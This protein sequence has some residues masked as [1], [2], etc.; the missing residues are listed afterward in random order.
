MDLTDQDKQ[1]IVNLLEQVSVPVKDAP[2]I[3]SIIVKLQTQLKHPHLTEA[4]SDEYSNTNSTTWENP[5]ER[6]E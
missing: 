1:I 4:L 3:Q 5:H 6:P 2:V